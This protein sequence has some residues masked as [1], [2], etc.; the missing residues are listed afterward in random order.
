M[1]SKQ[2]ANT[3]ISR[4]GLKKKSDE[5]VLIHLNA[6]LEIRKFSLE[7]IRTDLI[8]KYLDL[9][10]CFPSFL[11]RTII[12]FVNNQL[13]LLSK[14]LTIFLFITKMKDMLFLLTKTKTKTG[15]YC[16]ENYRGGTMNESDIFSENFW[17]IVFFFL[18]LGHHFLP[19]VALF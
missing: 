13:Y 16:K 18:S 14:R 10:V 15:F 12:F 7:K 19:I 4:N 9:M 8:G 5:L 1:R 6:I 17:N 11:Q 2:L 3:R